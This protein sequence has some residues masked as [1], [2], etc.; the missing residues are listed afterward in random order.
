MDTKPLEL[1]ALNH[2]ES[3]VAR[4]GYTYF[5]PNYDEKGGDF[6]IN[7]EKEENIY[8]GLKCQSKGRKVSPNGSSVVIPKGYV[9]DGFLA[10]VYVRPENPDETKTYLYT[11]NDIRT[12]WNDNG[13]SYS[14]SLSQNFTNNNENEKYYLNKKRSEIIGKLLTSVK[15]RIRCEDV[16]TIEYFY[17]LWRKTGGLP[18]VHYLHVVNEDDMSFIIDTRLFVFLLC[19]SVI[20]NSNDDFSLSID[21]AF[22]PLKNISYDDNEVAIESN[23]GHIYHSNVAITYYK[24]WV[25]EIL[26]RDEQLLGYHL[27]MGDSEESIDAY[28]MKDGEYGVSYKG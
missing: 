12:S 28:V 5:N 17:N 15:K 14:L 23:E 7:L 1:E 10:F 24:T 20:K 2:I 9:V 11:A 18:S 6:I 25:R 21:W 19:A 8:C 26:S 13:R 3:L 16:Q 4:Y 22:L 27:H